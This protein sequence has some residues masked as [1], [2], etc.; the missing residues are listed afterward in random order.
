MTQWDRLGILASGG[1]AAHKK[2][3]EYYTKYTA[4]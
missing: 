2:P 3:K 4:N 1:F